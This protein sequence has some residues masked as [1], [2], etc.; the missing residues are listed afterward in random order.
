MNIILNKSNYSNKNEEIS[1]D[2]KIKVN[3][4]KYFKSVPKLGKSGKPV[5]TK[6]KQK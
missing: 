1:S 3:K 5:Y 2:H 4:Q 6:T